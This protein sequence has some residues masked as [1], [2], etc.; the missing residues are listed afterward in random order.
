MMEDE[1]WN[2]RAVVTQPEDDFGKAL[3][4]VLSP[5]QPLQ[6][7]E[8]LR[9]REEQLDGIR[10]ALYAPGRHVFIHGFRGVGKS[11][12]AQTAAFSLPSGD[13][14]PIIL[15][16]DN[17][18]SFTRIIRDLFEEVMSR[19]PL[20]EKTI[21]EGGA[22]LNL[23]WLTGSAKVSTQEG[24]APEP[25]SINEAVRIVSF[26]CEKYNEQLVVVIDEFDQIKDK[27]EQENFANF[28]KQLSDKRVPARFIF[29]GIG[30]TVDAIMSAHASAD[31]Y[32]H[33]VSL[34]RLG[35]DARIEIVWVAAQRLG[36][37]ID[38][39]TAY[40]IA[41]ISDGFPHYVHLIAEKLFWR[42]FEAQNGGRVTG[43]LF[44]AA[45]GDASDAMEMK[46][47]APYD[48]ATRK[49]SNDNQYILFAVADGHELQR[50]STDIFGSY[51]RITNALSIEAL[52]RN[53]FN[54]RMNSLKQP[55]AGAI[56]S[57][58]RTGWY[59]FTEKVIRGYVRLRAEQARVQLEVDHPTA[60]RKLGWRGEHDA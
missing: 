38:H 10:K 32:F 21:K 20:V 24:K 1:L 54:T 42:V 58:N 36:V 4:H 56:L 52:D 37:E 16:C 35:W 14:D 59:E 45:M 60:R 57:A 34:D 40:R 50:R 49:Y 23:G 17:S 11:S 18:N 43:E 19:S 6:S 51:L 41:K 46:L 26:L 8:F 12:L 9:G 2:L 25:S 5:S 15:G 48:L 39:T 3:A 55:S 27:V 13:C 31:R 53:K 29:C 33:T 47:K 22:G 44:E 28:I 30:E 7:E